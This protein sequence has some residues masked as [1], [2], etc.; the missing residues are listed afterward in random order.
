MDS[1]HVDPLPVNEDGH[2]RCS[3]S[4]TPDADNLGRFDGHAQDAVRVMILPLHQPL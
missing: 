1:F 4:P 2:R 3:W